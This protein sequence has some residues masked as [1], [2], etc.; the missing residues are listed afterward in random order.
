MNDKARDAF[1][2]AAAEAAV[3]L[4]Q[5]D[6]IVGLGTRSIAT[7]AVEALAR[8]AQPH[9]GIGRRAVAR[10]DRPCRQLATGDRL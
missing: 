5:N 10:E 8:H 9:Q 2:H 4:V 7:F 3:A 1:K 6:M